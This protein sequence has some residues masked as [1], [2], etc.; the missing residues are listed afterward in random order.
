MRPEMQVYLER[1]RQAASEVRDFSG[2]PRWLENHTTDPIHND[3]KWSFREHE[4][5]MEILSDTT[6]EISMQ[7]CSQVGASE[8]WARMM[9]AMM[10][11]SKKIT[12]I[13][14]LPT[15][16]MAN[17]FSVGRLN[18]IIKDSNTL[19]RLVDKDVNNAV[20][21]IIGRSILYISGTYGQSNA[22]SVP[23]QALFRDEVDFC[24]QR[25][26]TTYDSRLGHS[27]EGE[28][29]KRSFSTPTVFKYGINLLYEAGSQAVYMVRCPKCRNWVVVDYFKD[30]VIPG[31][32]GT[33]REL[34]KDDLLNKRV[35]LNDAFFLCPKCH[36]VLPETAFH[37]PANRRWVHTFPDRKDHHSY[38]VLPIDVPQINP[39]KRTLNQMK[40]Y[41]SKKDWVNFKIG[42]PYEDAQSSFLE[43]KMDA[44]AQSWA[45]PRPDE[46]SEARLMSGCY[47]GVDVG[48]T[49]WC[50]IGKP[51][52]QGGLD[53]VYQE[54]I[55]Q[56]GDNYA[57]KRL[58]TLFKV[59]GCTYGV[60]DAGPDISLA[61]YMVKQLLGRFMACRYNTSSARVTTLDVLVKIDEEEGI[62]TVNRNALYD[63]LVKA[64]NRGAV[65]LSK[66]SGEYELAKAH[67]KS[68]KRVEMT[69]T[70]SGEMVVQWVSTGDDHYCH[71]GGY[72]EV[73]R[74]LR[75]IP[76]VIEVHPYIPSLGKV[77]LKEVEDKD[78]SRPRIILPSSFSR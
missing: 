61:Q 5:Q 73:A 35:K 70:E 27:K 31:W 14:I 41:D 75:A 28:A 50:T 39:L 62:V 9:L 10:A 67:F 15:S 3:R 4:Y 68:M 11:I 37:D 48:K 6:P 53:I 12:V 58:V 29:L 24:N 21:K 20:Q 38:Q 17:K 2:I 74:R 52:D 25:V 72:M 64:V 63:N 65:R 40:D 45:I 57:G 51:N 77:R 47:M 49:S 13:Y 78:E 33:L 59:F 26:L 32:D 30:V 55:R 66:N 36:D 23:A 60:I 43:E 76:Q 16:T 71:S 22:I 7:K 42:L 56:D 18:P 19:K 44:Y 8:I 34:E 54:R 69:D 1:L 46:D